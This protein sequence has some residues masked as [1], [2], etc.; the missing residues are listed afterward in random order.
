MA[1]VPVP[2]SRD[3]ATTLPNTSLFP[4]RSQVLECY[5]SPPDTTL[6]YGT[7]G[8]CC[9]GCSTR[10]TQAGQ[11]YLRCYRSPSGIPKVKLGNT[12]PFAFSVCLLLSAI[13]FFLFFDALY[14][15]KTSRN[16]KKATFII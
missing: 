6:L 14:L 13:Q 8:Y 2:P 15:P 4:W 1:V 3:E 10:S 5:L 11:Q 16:Q 9:T 7:M 12:D